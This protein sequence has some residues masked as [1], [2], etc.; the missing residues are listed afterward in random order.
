MQQ[1]D[2]KVVTP[3]MRTEILDTIDWTKNPQ[4]LIKLW[5]GGRG[6]I[7]F[8]GLY[9]FSKWFVLKYIYIK[10]VQLMSYKVIN[11]KSNLAKKL[12]PKTTP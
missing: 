4:G 8:W 9:E 1:N 5:E 11:P 2:S 12:C 6:K 7:H 3:W 10:P